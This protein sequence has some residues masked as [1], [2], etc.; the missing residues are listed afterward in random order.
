[1]DVT[2]HDDGSATISTANGDHMTVT[3]QQ[4]NGLVK[5]AKAGLL[6]RPTGAANSANELRHAPEDDS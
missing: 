2:K 1:M 3:A 4:M 5:A 6:D